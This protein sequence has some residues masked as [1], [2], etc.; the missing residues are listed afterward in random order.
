MYF[1]QYLST[2]SPSFIGKYG[3]ILIAFSYL[4]NQYIK[5]KNKH[6][7]NDI[8]TVFIAHR[9]VTGNPNIKFVLLV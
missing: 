5:K 6:K 9:N 3:H 4:P 1:L 8:I 7:I 2:I